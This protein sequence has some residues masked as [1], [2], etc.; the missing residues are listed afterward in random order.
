[1]QTAILLIVAALLLLYALPHLAPGW[2][3]TWEALRGRVHPASR[4]ARAATLIAVTV[5]PVTA[6]VPAHPAARRWPRLDER[7]V[8]ILL[9]ASLLLGLALQLWL[10]YH[11]AAFALAALPVILCG[12][13]TA[14]LLPGPPQL[15]EPFRRAAAVPG[16]P[17]VAR[18]AAAMGLACAL[19]GALLV[20][21][22]VWA[23]QLWWLAA[24]AIP[25]LGLLA[26]RLTAWRSRGLPRPA[27]DWRETGTLAALFVLALAIRLPELTSSPPFVHGDEA[28]C[29]LYARLFN[30]GTV[31]VLSIGWHSLPMASYAISGLGLRLFGDTL[32]GLRMINS[33]IGAAAVLLAYLLGRELFGRR[34]ALL[35]AL[36]LSVT[37]LHVDLSRSGL[38]DIQGPTC[39]TLT[40]LLAARWLRRGGALTALLTGMSVTLDMQMHWAAR[41]APLLLVALLLFIALRDRALWALRRRE[42]AW[43]GV[44]VIVSCAPLAALFLAHSGDLLGRDGAILILNPR[45]APH[46]FSV[47][48]TTAPLSVLLNQVWRTW[49]TFYVRGDAST[50]IDRQGGMFDTVSAALLA[51]GL[52]LLLPRWKNW[53]YALV[54]GWFGAVCAASVLTID[55][56]WWPRLA[57][58][59]P[60][61]ALCMG[62]ALAELTR[63]FQQ[64]FAAGRRWVT[65]GLAL[66]LLCIAIGNLRLVYAEYPAAERQ[67]P[68]MEGTLV[69]RFLAAAP[70]ARDTVL[71]S[72]GSLGLSAPAIRFLAPRAGGCVLLAGQPLQS[73]PAARL[74]VALPGRI[75]DLSHAESR[76]PGGRIVAVGSYNNGASRILA[77][78]LP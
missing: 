32:T 72:D 31:P 28:M 58:L 47:Y 61:A 54:L 63:L 33:F 26:P 62:V 24:L 23:A 78:E 73:C 68:L 52:V 10:T 37:F 48:G 13:L 11:P 44:G 59:L 9:S 39:V 40:L 7:A 60:A 5:A 49:S 25:V 18:G 4:V 27:I 16:W 34:A 51:P 50:L 66:V 17:L 43:L 14:L 1:M 57:A 38:H 55:P 35:G 6:P 76:Y 42:T 3:A 2:P 74:Y 30:T 41:V 12:A 77:Y 29:G 46:I 67:S 56:P 22:N 36:V 20:T 70:G 65:L 53:Q 69:G 71:L 8:V 45:T 19:L 75:G 64:V 21:S 15:A